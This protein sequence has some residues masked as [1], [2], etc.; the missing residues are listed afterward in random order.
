MPPRRSRGAIPLSADHDATRLHA[1][2][3]DSKD[4]GQTRRLLAL[5]AMYRRATRTEA[6]VRWRVVDLCQ[7]LWDGFAVSGSQG[8]VGGMSLSGS[9][10]V[11]L[12]LGR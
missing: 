12:G 10:K 8:A 11:G 3:R 4:A 6:A 9:G 5:A 2:A 7:W 1:A